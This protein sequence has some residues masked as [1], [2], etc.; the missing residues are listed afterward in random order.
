MDLI[1]NWPEVINSNVSICGGDNCKIVGTCTLL[2]VS[3]DDD[4]R[5][6]E[7]EAGGF[8]LSHDI[9]EISILHEFKIL[10]VMF[11]FLFFDYSLGWNSSFFMEGTITKDRCLEL[12]FQSNTRSTSRCLRWLLARVSS[13]LNRHL[14][15][16][17]RV[18][19]F[20]LPEPCIVCKNSWNPYL[21][22]LFPESFSQ[23]MTWCL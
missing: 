14:S 19:K 12:V 6:K 15:V 1:E 23:T 21:P 7:S 2:H 8:T 13:F 18:W 22:A 16:S 10:F 11:I 9:C 5:R 4:D 20:C 3:K 17:G